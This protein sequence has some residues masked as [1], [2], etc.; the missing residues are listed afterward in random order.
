M[1]KQYTKDRALRYSKG[2]FSTKSV[3]LYVHILMNP[4]GLSSVAYHLALYLCTYLW[5][6]HLKS[7][8]I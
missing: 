3:Y 1:K 4:Q 6:G 8:A 5:G 7:Y 2:N